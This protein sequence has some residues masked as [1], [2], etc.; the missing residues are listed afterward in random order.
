[1]E[2][3]NHIYFDYFSVGSA[4]AAIFLFLV[5]L[6]VL[7]IPKKSSATF[8]LGLG[9]FMSFIQ[10]AAY[11]V[12]SSYYDPDAAIHRW[13]TVFGAQAT[14]V[15]LIQFYL[16]YP[17]N[18]RPK[19]ANIV[20]IFSWIWTFALTGY[21]IYHT[22]DAA[23]IYHYAGHYWDYD[24]DKVSGLVGKFLLL[25]ALLWFI[26]GFVR[27]YRSNRKQDRI[28]VLVINMAFFLT[29]AI[30]GYLNLLSRDGRMDREDFQST[31][32]I[33]TV[34]STFIIVV[35]YI[36]TTRERTTF[37]AKIVGISLATFLLVLQLLSYFALFDKEQA[38]DSVHYQKAARSLADE[39]YRPP[40]LAYIHALDVGS[41]A[42]KSYYQNQRGQRS[43]R[44]EPTDFGDIEPGL[45]YHEYI[46]TL[47]WVKIEGLA[48]FNYNQKALR[49]SLKEKLK[50]SPAYFAGYRDT[51]LDIISA[52][53]NSESKNLVPQTLEY[54]HDLKRITY[55]HSKKIQDIPNEGFRTAILAYTSKNK[56]DIKYISNAIKKY[57]TD[58]DK[59][60]G[61][62]A[63]SSG[64]PREGA[65]LK[66]DVLNF[67]APFHSPESRRYRT[68][69]DGKRHYISFTHY[70]PETNRLYEVGY[71]YLY[72]REFI[73]PAATRLL[74]MLCAVLA[75][76]LFGFR[77]FFQ[78]ALVTPLARLLQAVEKVNH[79]DL[80]VRVPIKVEDE[81]GFLSR[82]FNGMVQSILEAKEKLQIYANELEDKVKERTADLKTTLDEVQVLK[83]KQDGDYFLTSLLLKP[84]GTNRVNKSPYV[85]V[86]FLVKQK[87]QFQF[88]KWKN[89]EIGG[90]ICMAHTISL[91]DK[92]YTVFLNAD[93]MGK[94]MQGAGGA[95]VLGA[96]F[97]SNVERT[98]LS[99]GLM[100]DPPELW[101]TNSFVELHKVF[102]GFDGSM[103]VS[104][105]MGLVDNETG[106]T[107]YINAEHPW[108]ALYRGGKASFIENDL[109]F[110]KLGTQG[111]GGALFVQTLQL[112]PGD[113]LFAGSDGRDDFLTEETDAEGRQ[114][115]NEDEFAFLRAVEKSKGNIRG[116]YKLI[117]RQGELTD[118]LSILR[119][120]YKGPE[121][122][123]DK[124]TLKNDTEIRL[125]LNRARERARAGELDAAQEI[126]ENAYELNQNRSDTL[127]ALVKTGLKK[128]DYARVAP[129]AEEY[130]KRDPSDTE[131][132]Y[133][134]SFCYKKIGKYEKSAELGE[135]VR[136]RQPENVKN[137]TNLADIYYRLGNKERA[138]SMVR[139]A[140]R[141][142]ADDTRALQLKTRL[143]AEGFYLEAE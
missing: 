5:G 143:E 55:Y 1:M 121:K 30:G 52:K 6:F 97:E 87:K 92:D 2:S 41:G 102:E 80:K 28:M 33:L 26:L 32:V 54:A 123:E 110:R 73:H 36:N 138:L 46:N 142:D 35:M 10:N 126:L 22:Q 58:G 89:E 139:R 66:K 95:L 125:L 44:S 78:G 81:I 48:S 118:D 19:L 141:V 128:K 38:Y 47:Y 76:V 135:R 137:I 20:W 127:K 15:Q 83:Q 88:K 101:L 140:L 71:H 82:S 132:V 85:D 104:I 111:M 42:F 120:Q 91:R 65:E 72:Y 7:T 99:E 70:S 122:I 68:S 14:S 17:I 57:I 67:L 77:F 130:I 117:R 40:E 9:F 12:S 4:I 27:A 60:K 37:M 98:R 129:L 115:L 119:L 39:N 113:T 75:V 50:D 100:T 13:F 106:F 3:L 21:F 34:I 124:T 69:P 23:Y 112:E 136:M 63:K 90:D 43:A 64:V 116:L 86:E 93:A 29:A 59:P 24:I 16:R 62:T 133:A 53:F 105:A 79:G 31:W 74:L 25:F 11:I 107:Y 108:T 114:M 131:L 96:V 45:H 134:T 49:S 84:L 18:A 109:T 56:G 8:H 94:S 51:L 61:E 103:L